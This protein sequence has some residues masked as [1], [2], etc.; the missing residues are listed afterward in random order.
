MREDHMHIFGTYAGVNI[1]I[2][3]VC[4]IAGD[5]KKNTSEVLYMEKIR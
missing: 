4:E 2:S 5:R 1:C 3:K